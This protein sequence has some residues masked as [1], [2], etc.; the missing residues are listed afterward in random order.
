MENSYNYG[1]EKLHVAVGSL[2]GAVDYS[3][4]ITNAYIFSLININAEVNIPEEIRERYFELLELYSGEHTIAE[5]VE[6]M[7]ND[8][9]HKIVENIVGLYDQICRLRGAAGQL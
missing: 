9:K 6:A 3:E 5:Q 4:R 2:T 1:W 7:D 8:K